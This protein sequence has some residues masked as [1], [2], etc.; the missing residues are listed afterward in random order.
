MS[1]IRKPDERAMGVRSSEGNCSFC[2]KLR[3]E[4]KTMVHGP[5]NVAICNECAELVYDISNEELDPTYLVSCPDVPALQA[6]VNQIQAHLQIWRSA[7]APRPRLVRDLRE[8]A[9]QLEQ[10]ATAIEE[11]HE[12]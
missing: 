11:K 7:I 2:G 12:S 6:L 3:G 5:N 4:V 10:V 9:K 8:V 1:K